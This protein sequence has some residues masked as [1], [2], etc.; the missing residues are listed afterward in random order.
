MITRGSV[1]VPVWSVSRK[2]TSQVSPW[3]LETAVIAIRLSLSTVVAVQLPQ[4]DWA[5]A[6]GRFGSMLRSTVAIN[7]A[8][9]VRGTRTRSIF[10]PPFRVIP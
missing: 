8:A 10:P 7:I 2:A 3:K 1:T 4:L 5:W 9:S 6:G